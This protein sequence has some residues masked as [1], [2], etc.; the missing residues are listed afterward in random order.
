MKKAIL[1][2]LALVGISCI[3]QAQVTTKDIVG[4]WESSETLFARYYDMKIS[5]SKI[6]MVI[7]PDRFTFTEWTHGSRELPN[8]GLNFEM[9]LR[10]EMILGYKLDGQEMRITK[11]Y[12]NPKVKI[13]K[14]SLGGDKN[15]LDALKKAGVTAD[16]YR[17]TME[18]SM[19]STSSNFEM[20]SFVIKR[21]TPTEMVLAYE[22][23]TT[24]TLRKAS[25]SQKNNTQATAKKD[26]KTAQKAE[27]KAEKEAVKE[28]KAEVKAEEKAEKEAEKAERKDASDVDTLSVAVPDDSID[29]AKENRL[30]DTQKTA[31]VKENPVAKEQKKEEPKEEKAWYTEAW[32]TFLSWF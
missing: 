17:P 20:V 11:Y 28:E 31:E 21:L 15:I 9:N 27:K 4:T 10:E 8:V 32:E 23:T 29:K 24:I 19:N 13:E 26:N 25:D 2:F 22:G 6:R 18:Q 5:Y 7:T 30:A 16:T 3:T 14:Y 12:Q 1:F